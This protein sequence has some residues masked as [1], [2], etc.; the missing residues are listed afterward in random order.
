MTRRIDRWGKVGK[1]MYENEEAIAAARLIAAMALN[2]L[3][4]PGQ[5]KLVAFLLY[6]KMPMANKTFLMMLFTLCELHSIR[7]S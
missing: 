2:V 3:P 1:A 6:R 7:L 4:G 5:E